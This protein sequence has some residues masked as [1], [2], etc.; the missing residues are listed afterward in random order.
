MEDK[1]GKARYYIHNQIHSVGARE[2]SKV[3]MGSPAPTRAMSILDR[4]LAEFA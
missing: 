3:T 2:A 1:N 4:R